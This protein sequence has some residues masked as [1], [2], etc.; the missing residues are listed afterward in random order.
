MIQQL[1]PN[2]S[3]PVS[4]NIQ[5]LFRLNTNNML[6]HSVRW[7]HPKHHQFCTLCYH[8]MVVFNVLFSENILQCLRRNMVAVQICECPLCVTW[9]FPTNQSIPVNPMYIDFITQ[10]FDCKVYISINEFYATLN[11]FIRFCGNPK[12]R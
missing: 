3:T 5:H 12:I 8:P 4:A 7:I 9:H 1:Q 11:I 10:V 6:L 2:K